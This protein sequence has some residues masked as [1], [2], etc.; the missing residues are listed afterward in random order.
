VQISHYA[1]GDVIYKS[2]LNRT[3]APPLFFDS[4]E[5]TAMPAPVK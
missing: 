1:N 5:P 3:V 2:F 4:F